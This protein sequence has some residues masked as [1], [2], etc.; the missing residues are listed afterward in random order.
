MKILNIIQCTNL[1]G[2][3]QASLRLMIA[4]QNRGH[5]LELISLTPLGEL[6]PLLTEAGIPAKGLKYG[7]TSPFSFVKSL[8]QAIK[9]AKADATM[10]TGHNLLASTA[11][12]GF[13]PKPRLM[14]M[15]FH[16]QGVMLP[17][18]W[19]IIY[20]PIWLG[21]DCVTY[22]SDYVRN[23]AEEILPPLRRKT[24][25]LRNPLKPTRVR[26]DEAARTFRISHRI[27]CDAPL[28]G[29]AGWLI[30]R[31][32]FD[33]FLE[34]AARIHNKLPQAHFIIA[35]GGEQRDE[36]M[37]LADRLGLSGHIHWLGWMQHMAEFYA[38]LD[39]LLFNSDWDAFPT[40]PVEAM[41]Y[42]V[43]VVAS[44]KHGGLAEI[45]D[46]STGWIIDHHDTDWLASAVLAALG[47]EG[48][49]RA[50]AARQRVELI[51]DPD[52]I[53]NSVEAVLSR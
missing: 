9:S 13:A 8:R 19:R 38:A 37:S 47:P 50:S 14:A 32:R 30:Q 42:S 18:R 45:L 2:M 26:D 39:V 10:M 35:G 40:T 1:G 5:S 48:Y 17:W 22:P 23:E 20:T 24:M 53:A 25:T 34:T 15:H 11:L 52:S 28:I 3:E 29:N 6:E 43:P 21:F 33:V 16:H 27:P 46:A 31:K 12:L 44:A 36:L 51:S 7:T 4:L 49:S 41:A